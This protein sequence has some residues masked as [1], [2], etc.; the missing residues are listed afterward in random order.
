MERCTYQ[1]MCW[2]LPISQEETHPSH[3]SLPQHAV[4]RVGGE[5]AQAVLLI[6]PLT[7]PAEQTVRLTVD[8]HN[9]MVRRRTK[10]PHS[11]SL[12]LLLSLQVTD[13][14]NVT[15]PCQVGPA[16]VGGVEISQEHFS[17]FFVARVPGLGLTQYHLWPG[18]EERTLASVQTINHSPQE[19][20]THLHT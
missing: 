16:W 8:T 19:R 18:T 3:D 13:W 9:V 10:H 15:V 12:F 2:S 4:V 20:Y 17:L 14:R 6:N 7:T 1:L 5:G 11:H